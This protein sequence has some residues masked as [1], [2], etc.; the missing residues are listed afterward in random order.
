MKKIQALTMLLVVTV[1]LASLVMSSRVAG[2]PTHGAVTISFDDSNQ[3]LF[4][5]AWPAMQARGIVGTFYTVSS[6]IRDYSGDY[7][8]MGLAELHTLQDA[9]N[10]IGSHSA[11]HVHFEDLNDAQIAWE[12]SESKQVLQSNGF[13]AVNF[14]FPYGDTNDPNAEHIDSIVSQYYRSGRSAYNDVRI[15]TFP[16][17]LFRLP[18]FPAETGD[19]SVLSLVES[20]IDQAYNENGWIQIY[21]HNVLPN[22]NDDPY[23]ISSQ[24]FATILDYI[25]AK[26]MPTYTVNQAL[27]GGVGPLSV[28]ASPTSVRMD[29]GESQTFI[30]SVSG[31]VPPYSYQW[32]QNGGQVSGVTGS[33]WTFTPTQAGE[34]NVYTRVTDSLSTVVNSNIVTDIVVY[35]FSR[36]IM[37]LGD[38]ITV[39]Y[40]GVDGYRKDLYLNLINSGSNVDF[41]GSQHSGTGLDDDHEGHNG[42]EANA[43]RDNVYGWLEDN[44]ADV[45]LL[46]I[47]TNDIYLEQDVADIVLEVESILDNIDQ[48]EF[49]YGESVTVI[50]ARIILNFNDENLKLATMEYN[51]ALEEM[52]LARIATGDEIIIVD[53]ENALI[54]PDDLIDGVHPTPAGYEKMADV[55][56]NVLIKG[57]VYF[58]HGV[59]TLSFDDNR[60]SQFTKV[61][62]LLQERGM[63]STFYIVTDWLDYSNTNTVV[64]TVGDLAALDAAGN[65]ITSH[66]LS[67]AN[68]VDLSDEQIREDLNSSKQVLQSLGFES[69]NFAYP[70]GSYDDR[71]EN[72]TKE[73]Y[74]SARSTDWL[75]NPI[76]LPVE[77]FTFPGFT[78]ETGDSY[79]LENLRE[80]VDIVRD[81]PNGWGHFFFHD[82]V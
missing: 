66:T 77:E 53:M 48:W 42:W 28:W 81:S 51:D 10:E 67:H 65:E 46:H 1:V 75:M 73:F 38:S 74:R 30:S 6:L 62:P 15:L 7:L 76:D 64:L 57:Q 41:V 9:G 5:Y 35:P 26:G 72:I 45:V 68:L 12:C 39:G 4:D 37:P 3:S 50:L 20:A 70:F 52:A 79:A 22:V 59:I 56:Y 36:A 60:K 24:D 33:T 21:F 18:G 61:F 47:G 27:D 58:P 54:Y 78:G 44:S 23:T 13:S 31:G 29:V 49:V 8:R 71:V 11:T 32:Y 69:D 40:P 14:A 34:Y 80:A 63:L 82:V 17:D 16:I 25:V 55:W 43:I 19:S 2:A